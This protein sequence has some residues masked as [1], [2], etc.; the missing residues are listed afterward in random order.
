MGIIRLNLYNAEPKKFFIMTKKSK[1]KINTTS[2]ELTP[3]LDS[4]ET[5]NHEEEIENSGLSELVEKGKE[6]GY[7]SYEDINEMLPEDVS[8]PDQVEEAIHGRYARSNQ[9]SRIKHQSHRHFRRYTARGLR[10]SYRVRCTRLYS[11]TG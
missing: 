11:Q 1:R 10:S 9:K 3:S 4:E 7:L 5:P 6:Q 2:E 8:D